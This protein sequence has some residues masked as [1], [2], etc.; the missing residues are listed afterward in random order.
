MCLLRGEGRSSSEYGQVE[1]HR[2]DL[3]VLPM[4]AAEQPVLHTAGPEGAA[5]YF[6]RCHPRTP[7]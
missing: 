2:G 3:F 6:V 4:T 1:W 5:L 7:P